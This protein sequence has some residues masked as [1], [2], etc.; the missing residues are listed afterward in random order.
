MAVKDRRNGRYDVELRGF[1]VKRFYDAESADMVFKTGK[2]LLLLGKPLHDV[3]AELRGGREESVPKFA[4]YSQGWLEDLAIERTSKS[5]YRNNL[6]RASSL[7]HLPISEIDVS[8]LKSLTASLRRKGYAPETIKRTLSTVKSVLNDACDEGL[9]TTRPAAKVRGMPKPRQV[10]P[11]YAITREQHAAIVAAATTRARP[12]FAVWP[13]VGLRLGEMVELRW[14]DIDLDA[15]R[16][17]VARQKRID[18]TVV[19]PKGGKVR[20]IDICKPALVELKELHKTARADTVFPGQHGGNIARCSI[21]R[22]CA[23]SGAT[24]GID[25]FHTHLFRHT[26]GSWLIQAGAPLTYIAAQMGDTLEVVTRTYLHDLEE[27][28]RRGM[29]AFNR[30]ANGDTEGTT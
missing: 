29:M 7:D 17:T 6:A 23:E 19:P 10:R 13:W 11:G 2:R 12:M 22:W 5:V 3:I 4:A 28:D 26:F 27:A 16:M 1:H 14:S 25:G 15:A 18:G 8:V 9:I 20:S 30:W 21:N 24:A